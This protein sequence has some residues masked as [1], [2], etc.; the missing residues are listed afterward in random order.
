[1][2]IISF[3]SIALDHKRGSFVVLILGLF[4]RCARSEG[5][6]TGARQPQ[7]RYETGRQAEVTIPPPPP[8]SSFFARLYFSDCAAVCLRRAFT[9]S[10]PPAVLYIFLP[11]QGNLCFVFFR[12]RQLNLSLLS[13]PRVLPDSEIEGGGGEVRGGGL[14]FAHFSSRPILQ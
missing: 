12:R 7:K 5:E 2:D 14:Q 10:P 1:M 4:L 8:T 6:M 11:S 9:L 13:H 3:F